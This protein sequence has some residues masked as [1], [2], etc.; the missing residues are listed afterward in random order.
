MPSEGSTIYSQGFNFGSFVLHGVDNRTGQYTCSVTLYEALAEARNCPT[1]KLSLNYNALNPEDIGFGKGWAFNLSRY[2]H[3]QGRTISLLKSFRFEKQGSNYH[4]IYKSGQRKILSNVN[5]VYKR[6]IPIKIFAAIGRSLKLSWTPVMS[7]P[8]LTKVS[9]GSQD[10]LTIKCESCSSTITCHPETPQSG[11]FVLT[12][13]DKRLSHVKL[14]GDGKSS[15][16]RS[17]LEFYL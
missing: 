7:V 11:T 9:D 10:L 8:R 17:R 6:S 5:N 14:P 12:Q 16:D 3:R 15:T 2:Q 4:V 1:F 13:K